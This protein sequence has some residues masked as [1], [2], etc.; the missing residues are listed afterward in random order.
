MERRTPGWEAGL[1]WCGVLFEHDEGEEYATR[2]KRKDKFTTWKELH[3]LRIYKAQRHATQLQMQPVSISI[4][5]I[6]SFL[7]PKPWFS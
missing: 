3:S 6:S 1:R 5:I 2:S 7:L 4:I